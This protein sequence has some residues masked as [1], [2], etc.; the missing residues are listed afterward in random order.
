MIKIR[1]LRISDYENAIKIWQKAGI[2]LSASDRK[3]EIDKMLKHNPNLCLALENNN[4]MIGLVLGGFDGR[5]GWIHH[6]AVLP[7]FQGKGYGKLLMDELI[8]RFKNMN[9]VKVKLEVVEDNRKVIEFYKHLGWDERPEIITMSL[10]LR[11]DV[12]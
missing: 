6:L 12:Y 3:D 4:Q 11:E 2:H 9:I 5:R 10:S 8:S 7:E 1:E